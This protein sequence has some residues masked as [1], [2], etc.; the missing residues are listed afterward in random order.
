MRIR[1][2]LELADEKEKAAAVTLATAT[3]AK[4]AAAKRLAQSEGVVDGNS[5]SKSD[6]D[7]HIFNLS[8]D[9]SIFHDAADEFEE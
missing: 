8:W 2:Q 7:G 1:K 3:A 6:A 5:Q 9:E 4:Q